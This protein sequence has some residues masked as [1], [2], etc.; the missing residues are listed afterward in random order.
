MKTSK[1][2][3]QTVNPRSCAMCLSQ[4]PEKRPWL[5]LF[6]KMDLTSGNQLPVCDY[7]EGLTAGSLIITESFRLEKSLKIMESNL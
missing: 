2:P 1:A 7:R 4:G 6:M 3:F 5:G